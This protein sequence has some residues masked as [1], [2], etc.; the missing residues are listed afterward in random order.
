MIKWVWVIRKTDF[1]KSI[2]DW[3]PLNE[4]KRID[5]MFVYTIPD[6]IPR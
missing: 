4:M 2:F 3:F 5:L 6:V 1:V